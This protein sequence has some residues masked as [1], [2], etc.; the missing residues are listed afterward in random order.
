MGVWDKVIPPEG[1]QYRHCSLK[2]VPR[3]CDNSRML[4]IWFPVIWDASW[5][6]KYLKILLGTKFYNPRPNEFT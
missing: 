2:Y 1:S 3:L 5:F 4:V 6:E